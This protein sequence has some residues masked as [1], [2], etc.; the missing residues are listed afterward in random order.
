M[1]YHCGP[2]HKLTRAQI[3]R[4][5]RWHARAVAFRTTHGT[6]RDVAR[7]LGVKVY[8][9][10]RALQDDR[11]EGA[12]GRRR[13]L[14]PA[15]H[16]LVRRWR[17]AGRRFRATHLTAQQLADAQGVSRSTIHDCIRRHGRYAA[18]A[19]IDSAHINARSVGS[20]SEAIRPDT[21]A[22]VAER[23]ALLGA[24]PRPT[25]PAQPR[26][27]AGPPAKPSRT[28]RGERS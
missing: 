23:A 22:A 16:V 15:Q 12:L 14:S 28:P 19:P 26:R 13:L 27:I 24:W 11:T 4:V 9:V 7:R 1:C 25:S 17:A 2:P 8:A 6:A 18:V 21:S 20:R 3:R 10:R 5:L